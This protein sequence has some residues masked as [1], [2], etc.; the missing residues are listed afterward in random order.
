MRFSVISVNADTPF[1]LMV[2]ISSESI[3]EC[4]GAHSDS[5]LYL[6]R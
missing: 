4:R 1:E 3:H 2:L 6:A 5:D